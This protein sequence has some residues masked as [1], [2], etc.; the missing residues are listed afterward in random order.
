MKHVTEQR[1]KNCI[2]PGTQCFSLGFALMN[3]KNSFGKKVWEFPCS[4]VLALL[5][6]CKAFEIKELFPRQNIQTIFSCTAKKWVNLRRTH[7]VFGGRRRRSRKGKMLPPVKML[8]IKLK[9]SQMVMV[10][11][12]VTIWHDQSCKKYAT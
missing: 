5:P 7:A 9:L 3:T 11:A 12:N 10:Q 8:V 4:W 1:G 6:K 2:T